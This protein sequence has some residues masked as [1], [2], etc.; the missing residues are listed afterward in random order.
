MLRYNDK[1]YF[2]NYLL[3]R[4]KSLNGQKVKNELLYDENDGF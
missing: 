3:R 1:Y 2:K 4:N